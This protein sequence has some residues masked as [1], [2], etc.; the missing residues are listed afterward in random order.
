MERNTPSALTVNRGIIDGFTSNLQ[1]LL[2]TIPDF[3][4]EMRY[5]FFVT[6]IIVNVITIIHLLQHY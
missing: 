5:I 2:L 6:I 3:S 1:R 4:G